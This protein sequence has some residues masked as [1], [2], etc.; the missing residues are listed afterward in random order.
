M[1]PEDAIEMCVHGMQQH[2]LLEVSRREPK[3]FSALSSAVAAT[4]LEF[5]KSPQI[6]ELYKKA[7]M[8]DHAKHFNS[9]AKP[10]NNG[11][12]PKAPNE[13]NTARVMHQSDVP[14]L[15]GRNEPA[16][17]R[18]RPNLQELLRKQYVFRREMIKGFF[19]QVVAHNHLNLPEPKR[20]DQVN[21]TDNP[22][23]CP[24]H[25]YVGHV[26]EDCVAFKEWLQR[27]IDEKR[28]QLQPDAVNPGYH[29]VN[30]VTVGS[31][32][33]VNQ[34]GSENEIWVPLAQVENNLANMRLAHD[35]SRTSRRIAQRSRHYGRNYGPS[36]LQTRQQSM[37]LATPH[38][39]VSRIRRSHDPSRRRMP[40][41]FVPETEG[42]ESFPRLGRPLPTLA[43]FMPR[44]W[45]QSPKITEVEPFEDVSPSS[46]RSN[47]S[48]N[49]VIQYDK[50][51]SSS[52]DETILTPEEVEAMYGGPP[53]LGSSAKEVNMNL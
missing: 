12:K 32:G 25:R 18:P 14:M 45:G 49:V 8:T 30:M 39:D 36:P 23:Y 6:M 41:R 11:V 15:R 4:K 50:S 34:E 33:S 47:T 37:Y 5:E 31:G 20:P 44:T 16:G 19:N 52:S 43:H 21:L 9:M 27:A 29:S 51:N 17:A 53:S 38:P 40:P 48:C 22:L 7:S 3:T 2:W 42:D 35:T 28:L 1:H 10:N 46:S 24:Y 26:I 13:V